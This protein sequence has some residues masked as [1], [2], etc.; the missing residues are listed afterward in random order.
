VHGPVPADHDEEVGVRGS[1]ARELGQ[2]AP[3]LRKQ[4]IAAQ[5]ERRGL[6]SELRP[7]SSRG[8]VFGGRVDEKDRL[9]NGAP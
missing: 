4:R 8:A 9:L 3:V 5:P 7:P 6:V 2:V 1:L